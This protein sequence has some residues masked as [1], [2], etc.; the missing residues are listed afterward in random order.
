MQHSE[1]PIFLLE[2]DKIKPNPHQPRRHFDESAL[3][4]LASSIR[5]LGI[6]QPVVVTKNETHTETG[7]SIEYHLIAGERRLLAS[8]LAGLERIPAIIRKPANE[9]EKLEMA[10]V[11]NVQRENLDPIEA[12]RAYSKLQDE[13]GLTQREVAVRVGKSRE[14]IANTM[15]LLQ[16]PTTIQ[17][18]LSKHQINESQARMLLM[19]PD[20]KDQQALFEDLLKNNLSVRDLRTRIQ[21]I[22]TKPMEVVDGEMQ[23][24]DPEMLA[25]KQ[26]LEDALGTKVNFEKSGE[27]GKVIINFYSPEELK[28]LVQKLKGDHSTN[29]VQDGSTDSINPSQ[30]TYSTGSGQ[31]DF[32]S[33]FQVPPQ[34]P[35]APTDPTSPVQ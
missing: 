20:I 25:L 21:R 30:S 3:Q 31:E 19:L 16:L 13:F 6:L 33:T 5:E 10:I 1:G 34:E 35:Q 26:E 9:R 14:V 32:A 11:E 24:V 18:A 23:K 8:Q 29:S 2:V 12:A 17:E 15:R 28:G 4:E 22:K 7:T 27:T